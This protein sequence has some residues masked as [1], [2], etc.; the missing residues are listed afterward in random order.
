MPYSGSINGVYALNRDN[1]MGCSH[2]EHMNAFELNRKKYA[3]SF[4]KDSSIEYLIKFVD[5]KFVVLF[6]TLNMVVYLAVFADHSNRM[7]YYS[8]ER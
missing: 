7:Y 4:V 2:R 6:L 3:N 5:A 8:V 1:L